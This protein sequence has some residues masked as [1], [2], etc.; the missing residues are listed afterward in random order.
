MTRTLG[1]M[2]L[3]ALGAA[4]GCDARAKASDPQARE[5]QK[6]RELESCS[7]SVQ[8]QDDLRC[9]DSTCRRTT[10]SNDGDYYAALGAAAR[11]RGEL[12]AAIAAYRD[13]LARYDAEKVALPPEIDCAYG[14]T[15]A[16]AKANKEH[17][18]LAARV[19]HRCIR[20]VPVGSSLRDRA[21]ADLATLADV[22]LEPST[23]VR[24][25]PADL[26]LTR[27]PQRPA[28]DKLAVT[29]TASPPPTAKTYQG[30][31]D[32]IMAPDLHAA[33]AACWDA[34]NTA[35]K[36]DTLAVTMGVRSGVADSGYDDVP[37]QVFV[38]LDPPAA[39]MAAADAAADT[40]V[41]AAVEPALKT[42]DSVR[43]VFATK[44]TITVK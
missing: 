44:L 37:G 19:L 17:A 23:L 1:M 8:C 7:A 34:Y 22:G 14:T 25:Q 4:A 31:P 13:A 35:T 20:A 30:V 43:E 15:L 33:L 18:E 9:F 39:G 42:V 26:Y 24:T 12:D 29:V 32:R 21:F 38:R 41:R 5:D 36:K 28:A 16:L 27:A 2:I 40:C 10:R 6:S 3:V 11:T